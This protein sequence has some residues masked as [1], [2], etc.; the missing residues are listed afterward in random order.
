MKTNPVIFIVVGTPGSGKDFLVQAANDMGVLHC[1][2]VPKHTDRQRQTDDSNEMICANDEGY[3]LD[4]CDLTYNNYNNRYGIK[5]EL[6][7]DQLKMGVAQVLVVS[8]IDAINTLCRTFSSMIKLIFVHSEMDEEKYRSE[9]RALG[10][11]EKYI[12]A[13]V[14]DYNNALKIYYRN[15]ARF[16]HVLIYADS[17]EDLFDQIFRLFNHYENL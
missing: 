16:D 2:I 10:N 6:V 14:E 15:I 1:R 5:L 17:K 12:D 8:N 3:D 9:Q 11:S 7:W 13:R 4:K